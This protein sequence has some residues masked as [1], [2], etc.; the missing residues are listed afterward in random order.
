MTM[1]LKNPILRHC[2][3]HGLI[4][5]CLALNSCGESPEGFN[6]IV[7]IEARL[8]N[9]KLGWKGFAYGAITGTADLVVTDLNGNKISNP[10]QIDGGTFGA[11]AGWANADKIWSD[12]DPIHASFSIPGPPDIPANSFTDMTLPDGGIEERIIPSE[13]FEQA[14]NLITAGELFGNYFGG[15]TGL[16]FA[17]GVDGQF[18]LKGHHITLVL[19]HPAIGL[20][21]A[22]GVEWLAIDKR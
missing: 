5:L 16:A 4:L 7:I 10:V 2:R 12:A 9:L 8:E 19:G 6:E 13:S 18:L 3:W 1:S 21:L 17:L 22:V 14:A 15:Q 11:L 20:G